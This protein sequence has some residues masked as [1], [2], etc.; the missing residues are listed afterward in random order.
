MI[1]KSKWFQLGAA[2]ILGMVVLL[3]PR[4]EGTKF[5]ILGDGNQIFFQ[6]IKDTFNLVNTSKNPTGEY[7][8]EVKSPEITKS[9]GTY[10]KQEADKLKLKGLQVDYINGLSPTAKGRTWTTTLSVEGPEW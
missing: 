7:T 6:H 5:K 8:V 4:P 3:V 1:L 2:I 10:L 9:P